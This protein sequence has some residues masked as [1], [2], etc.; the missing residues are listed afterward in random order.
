MNEKINIEVTTKGITV[1][2]DG[3]KVA[4]TSFAAEEKDNSATYDFR[5]WQPQVTTTRLTEPLVTWA[6]L[7]N[8]SENKA[9]I[10]WPQNCSIDYEGRLHLKIKQETVKIGSTEKPYTTGLVYSQKIFGKGRTDITAIMEADKDIKETIWATTSPMV[11][12]DTGLKYLYEFDIVEYTSAD[13]GAKNTSRGLWVWQENQQS[14]SDKKLPYIYELPKTSLHGGW[15]YWTGSAWKQST[16]YPVY[17]NGNRLKGTN[18]KFY[19]ITNSERGK[20][21]SSNDLTWIRE[22]GVEGK[23]LDG[24]KY[25]VVDGSKAIG[26]AEKTTFLDGKTTIAGRHT[27]SVVV[28]DDYIAYECDGKEYYRIDNKALA[29]CVIRDGLTLN[30]IFSTVHIAG[31][32]FTKEHEL[33][34]ESVKYT[35]KE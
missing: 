13:T 24:N 6:A 35:P 19:F 15:W 18:G 32:A 33:V 25:F 34:I 27:W 31:A 2:A 21:F 12:P 28:E 29:P 20:D 16:L 14:V 3:V 8:I 1:Y 26:G 7:K 4:E 10:N 11:D 9:T 5:S 17:V 22:D 23:G 30:L